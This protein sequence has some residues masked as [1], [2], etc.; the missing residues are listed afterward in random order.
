MK[1]E[2]T[3]RE[4][5]KWT[6]GERRRRRR[7]KTERERHKNKRKKNLRYLSYS[8]TYEVTTNHLSLILS[9]NGSSIF[10]SLRHTKSQR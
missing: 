9:V 8:L 10:R 7:R 1:K 4:K 5:L 3:V 6:A 2:L